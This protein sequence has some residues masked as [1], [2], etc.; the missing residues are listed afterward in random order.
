[1]AA[2][3]GDGAGVGSVSIVL[4]CLNENGSVARVVSEA[5]EALR[6]AGVE[7]EVLV[8]DNGSTDGSAEAAAAAGARVVHERRRGYGSAYLAGFSA[9]RGDVIVMADADGSYDLSALPSFLE[10]IRAGDDVVI[11]S[12]FRGEIAP[13]AMPWLH[14]YVGNPILS[15]L[16]NRMYRTGVDDA[17]CGIRAFRRDALPRMR[18]RMRGMEFASEMVVNAARAGLR[19]GEVPVNYR[20]RTGASKLRSLRDGW[21]HLRF[22]LLYSPTHLFL[23]PGSAVL[24]LGL[25]LVLVLLPGPLTIG[26]YFLDIHWMVLGSMLALV[27]F[28]VTA[29]GLYAKVLAVALGL[30]QVDGTL[31]ALHRTFT[32]ERGL[33]AGATLFLIG[34]LVDARIAATWLAAGFG[35]LE[36]LRSAI[37]ALTTMV[38]GLQVA[39]S[40]FFL[41]AVDMQAGEPA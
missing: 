36:E 40:S 31:R 9:A 38:L 41:S 33:A 22:L 28:Q 29:L 14:R 37:F 24:V 2:R 6:A 10:R 4:P 8:A 26:P 12:R 25:L 13:G 15:G 35:A 16:L 39:F 19:I 17:H 34:F 7:G 3:N 5:R 20:V 21:R 18:L 27:G 30:Q 11:G 32:L 1:M 23:I